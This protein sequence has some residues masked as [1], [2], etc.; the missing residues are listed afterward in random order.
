MAKELVKQL[1]AELAPHHGRG[2]RMG[3]QQ[4]GTTRGSSGTRPYP[5]LPSYPSTHDQRGQ[6]FASERTEDQEE[7][8][9]HGTGNS[10]LSLSENIAATERDATK[11][12]RVRRE[13]Q[14]RDIQKVLAEDTGPRPPHLEA[15][16]SLKSSTNSPSG[17]SDL[18]VVLNS[19]WTPEEC[20][21][22]I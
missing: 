21:F 16:N 9:L 10:S 4:P 6:R 20:G 18:S 22:L 13:R 2:I 1:N 12:N 17:L 3:T 15:K 14:Q 11:S 8:K 7:P 5:R 19:W